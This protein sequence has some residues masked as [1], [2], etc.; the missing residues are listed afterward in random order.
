VRQP[1]LR[2]AGANQ[3]SNARRNP[4]SAPTRLTSTISPPGFKMRANSSSVASGSGTVVITYCATTTSNDAFGKDR[5]SASIT[6]RPSTL[7]SPCS[8]TRSFAL[9]SIGSEMSTPQR[10]LRGE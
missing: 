3:R 4:A 2:A 10:R 9:R 7:L 8:A 1:S 6:H 5:C